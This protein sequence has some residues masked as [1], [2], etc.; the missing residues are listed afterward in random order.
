[1]SE[2]RVQNASNIFF[3]KDVIH[4]VLYISITCVPHIHH[5]QS[6]VHHVLDVLQR[7]QIQ[8]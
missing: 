8:N 6:L 7:N 4:A 1:M 2:T 3:N 5:L